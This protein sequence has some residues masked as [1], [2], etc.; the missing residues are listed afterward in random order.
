MYISRAKI[1]P[2]FLKKFCDSYFFI[3]H[4]HNLQRCK[5]PTLIN[6]PL[7]WFTQ[8]NNL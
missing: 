4:Y 8:L 6:L 3:Q 5:Y 1:V 7:L 2:N